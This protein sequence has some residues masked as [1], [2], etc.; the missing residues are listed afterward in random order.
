LKTNLQQKF[1]LKIV[2]NVRQ[3]EKW[4]AKTETNANIDWVRVKRAK[5]ES[6]DCGHVLAPSS[7][8]CMQIAKSVRDL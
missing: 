5:G 2:Q 7:G 4:M 8:R 3:E 1:K 6:P